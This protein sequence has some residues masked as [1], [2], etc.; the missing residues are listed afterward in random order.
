VHE[1][2]KDVRPWVEI[3]FFRCF[4]GFLLDTC[5]LA[6]IRRSEP[7]DRVIK[8]VTMLK[9]EEIFLSVLTIGE[10]WK[11]ILLLQDGRKKSDL[12]AWVTGIVHKFADRILPIDQQ[13]AHI[14]AEITAKAQQ[15]GFVVPAVDGMIAATAIRSGLYVMTRN[16]KHFNA[17]GALVIDPWEES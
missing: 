12:T 1:L 15:A 14:W 2:T 13:S 6:E 10:I 8:R 5:V 11:G 4:M 9:D 3:A 16:T 17:V 7:N